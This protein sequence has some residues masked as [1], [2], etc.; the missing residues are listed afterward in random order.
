M[1]QTLGARRRW[2]EPKACAEGYTRLIVRR[3]RR[4]DDLLELVDHPPAQAQRGHEPLL[5]ERAGVE[6]GAQLAE[7]LAGLLGHGVLGHLDEDQVARPPVRRRE[8]HEALAFAG[9]HG[10]ERDGDRLSGGE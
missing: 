10:L 6:R 8:P 1:A 2:G 7:R 5:A 3:R 4:E 9:L